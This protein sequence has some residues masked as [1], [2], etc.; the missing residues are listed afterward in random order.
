MERSRKDTAFAVL[1][2]EETAKHMKTSPQD[3]YNRLERLGLA[4]SILF[5]CYDTLQT[6]S[7]EYVADTILNHEKTEAR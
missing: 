2:I 6:Q 4:Q 5:D 3:V 1:A 7:K